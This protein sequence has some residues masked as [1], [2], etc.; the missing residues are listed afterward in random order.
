MQIEFLVEEPSARAA[1][2]VLLPRLLPGQTCRIRDFDGWQDLLGSLP[3][4]L[5]GYHKRIAQHGQADLRVVVLLDGDGIGP[6]RKADLEAHAAR[7]GLLTKS[8]AGPGQVFQVLNR[9]AVQELEAWWLG[10]RAA[11]MAAYPGVRPHHFKGTPPNPDQP[12][13]PN[14][15]L[16]TVLKQG[17]HFLAGKRKTQWA[18]DISQHLD[19]ARNTSA[20]FRCFCQGLAALR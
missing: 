18:T 8:T 12:P 4:L 2:E 16:W 15:V 7:A 20:S 5:R 1:L 11:I 3:A 17:R 19:P 13:K 6:R 10:D 14:D 9:V